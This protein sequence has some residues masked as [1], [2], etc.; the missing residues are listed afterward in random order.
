VRIKSFAQ[1]K[2][3]ASFGVRFQLPEEAEPKVSKTPV[4]ASVVDGPATN[5]KVRKT[6]PSM[7]IKAQTLKS[8][9]TVGSNFNQEIQEIE[10]LNQNK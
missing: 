8:K 9:K 4:V 6:Q 7:G 2:S 10:S 5:P 3:A 1:S